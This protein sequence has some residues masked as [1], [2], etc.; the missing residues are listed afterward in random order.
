MTNKINFDEVNNRRGSDCK[1]FNPNLY[2]ETVLPMWIADTDFK[3]PKEVA[4]VANNRNAH[5]LYGYPYELPEFNESVKGWMKRRHDWEID[6]SHVEF[7]FGVVPACIYLIQEFTQPGDNIVLLTPLYSPLREAV[8]D[9]GRILLNSSMEYKQGNYE[10]NWEDFEA[11]LSNSKT[12]MLI[13]CNPHNPGGKVFTKD[14]LLKIGKLCL[15]NNILIFSDEIH[16]DIIYEDNKHIPIASLSKEIS[17]ITVTS[18]NPGKSF[19][20]AGVRTAAVIISNKNIM[21]RYILSRKR[22]KAMGRTVMGQNVFIA[23][24]K[25]GDEY[26]DQEVQ[27]LEMNMEFAVKFIEEN[28]PELKAYK[29][30]ATYL[31]WIDCNGLNLSQE[32]LMDLFEKEGKIA[33]NSGLSFGKEGNGFVRLNFAVPRPILEEGCNRLLRAVEYHRSNSLNN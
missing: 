3:V 28:I 26:I 21:T 23:C 22:N 19:N 13:L 8:V 5:E 25:Y 24:Y 32:E 4:E 14:E 6:N 27:Y 33:M 17:D 9:N 18:L 1:K 7:A 11:K 15:E 20:V 29:Q 12:R 30:Q 16:A 10:I 2:D 31:L